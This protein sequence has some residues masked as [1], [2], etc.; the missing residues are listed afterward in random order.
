M[1]AFT[2]DLQTRLDRAERKLREA[3]D[4]I[5]YAYA[6]ARKLEETADAL[7][8]RHDALNTLARQ[9]AAL[10]AYLAE[11]DQAPDTGQIG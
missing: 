1:T 11:P 6:A 5:A 2:D 9:R 7:K 4:L 10:Q 3:R 8:D